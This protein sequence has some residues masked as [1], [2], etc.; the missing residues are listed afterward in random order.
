[1]LKMVIL[2]KKNNVPSSENRTRGFSTNINSS[3]I[4]Y[5]YTI[6]LSLSHSLTLS[7]FQ[8]Q[9]KNPRNEEKLRTLT[10]GIRI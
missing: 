4:I 8:K 7:L 1:M 3:S 9:I 5:S 6:S 2:K 10:D